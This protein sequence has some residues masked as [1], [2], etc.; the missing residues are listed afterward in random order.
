MLSLR[1]R[2]VLTFYVGL[3]LSTVAFAFVVVFAYE[4]CIQRAENRQT[5]ALCAIASGVVL[6]AS[7]VSGASGSLCE[8]LTQKGKRD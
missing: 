6:M 4:A 7:V 8:A 1:T 3:V 2:T 5:M